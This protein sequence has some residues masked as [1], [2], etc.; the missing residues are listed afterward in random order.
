VIIQREKN[1][2]IYLILEN[3]AEYEVDADQFDRDHGINGIIRIQSCDYPH[4]PKSEYF[5]HFN[6][7]FCGHEVGA[8]YALPEIVR[9]GYFISENGQKLPLLAF[10]DKYIG[11]CI[12]VRNNL[13][14]NDLSEADFKYSFDH[15][16]NVELLRE[17]IVR[18]YS[19]S[20]PKF[21]PEE[22]LRLG[23][24]LTRLRIIGKIKWS[25]V[26]R[27]MR[28]VRGGELIKLSLGEFQA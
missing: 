3:G 6:L 18:R 4:F 25:C 20:L 2:G 24:S 22:I 9:S 21:S 13:S 5:T 19:V 1:T 28:M 16:K 7:Q 14:Y 8:T 12:E 17:T 10:S 26:L 15:I 27:I 11:E 23:V